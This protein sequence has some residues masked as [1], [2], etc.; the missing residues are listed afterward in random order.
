VAVLTR[1]EVNKLSKGETRRK[2]AEENV[3][4][5]VINLNRTNDA[6]IVDALARADKNGEQKATAM[7]RWARVGIEL[8]KSING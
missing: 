1:K 2:W 3:L 7:K 6:D 4:R 8:D 5:I